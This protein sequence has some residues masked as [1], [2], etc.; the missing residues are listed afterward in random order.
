MKHHISHLY[1]ALSEYDPLHQAWCETKFVK[2]REN[3]LI[4]TRYVQ[5]VRHWHEQ[6]CKHG[7][8]LASGQS[9]TS[10]SRATHTADIVAA[11]QCHE[12]WSHTHTAERETKRR[13]S[14]LAEGIQFIPVSRY[15]KIIKI[16]QDFPV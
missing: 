11:H 2:Y 14:S 9:A 12:L 13:N 7:N 6:T 5:N 3:K 4:V 8:V 1:N 10:P 15:V 16:H